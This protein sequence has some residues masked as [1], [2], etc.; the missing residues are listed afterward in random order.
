MQLWML[1]K[2][3][4]NAKCRP[5]ISPAVTGQRTARKQLKNR[6]RRKQDK[7]ND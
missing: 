7:Q 6:H 5:W 4:E 2:R 1:T 3:K